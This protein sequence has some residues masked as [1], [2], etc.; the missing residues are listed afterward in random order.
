MEERV[1]VTVWEWFSRFLLGLLFISGSVN[2]PLIP[3]LDLKVGM[4]M[5]AAQEW[6]DLLLGSTT[7]VVSRII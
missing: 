7:K 4:K 3:G 6:V 2:V 5:K 1:M